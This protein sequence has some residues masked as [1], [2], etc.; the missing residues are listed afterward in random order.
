MRR[1]KLSLEGYRSILKYVA[2]TS[3]QLD[4]TFQRSIVIT[5]AHKINI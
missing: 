3:L 4:K 5:I 2:W 1:P